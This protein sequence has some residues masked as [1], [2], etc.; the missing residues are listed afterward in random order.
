MQ[1]KRSFIQITKDSD[2]VKKYHVSIIPSLE[3]TK[4]S[5]VRFELFNPREEADVEKWV[6]FYKD[7]TILDAVKIYIDGTELNNLLEKSTCYINGDV[8]NYHNFGHRSFYNIYSSL[9]SAEVV[10]DCHSE[11]V[12][13]MMCCPFCGNSFTYHP[14]T[15]VRTYGDCVYWDN[16][17]Y[18]KDGKQ[19]NFRF[20]KEQ[21]HAALEKLKQDYCK[22]MDVA[23]Y[24]EDD[25]FKRGEHYGWKN[26]N[27][28]GNATN[29]FPT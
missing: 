12:L 8:D 11:Y 3:T 13:G 23:E 27:N 17:I 15:Y 21:Y 10:G 16:L 7:N 4:I 19:M 24:S 5:E 28:N 9:R 18:D 1:G 6:R 25:P 29:M 20:D 2:G 14:A 26:I 22:L